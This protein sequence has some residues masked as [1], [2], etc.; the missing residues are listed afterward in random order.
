MATPQSRAHELVLQFTHLRNAWS[1][2]FPH[3]AEGAWKSLAQV[4]VTSSNSRQLDLWSQLQGLKKGNLSAHDY[5]SKMKNIVD[6]LVAIGQPVPKKQQILYLF[7]GLGPDYNPF[8]TSFNARVETP[9]IDEV[10]CLLLNYDFR[11]EKQN[12]VEQINFP[13]GN[14][15]SYPSNKRSQKQF[16]PQF[17]SQYNFPKSHPTQVQFYQPN[18]PP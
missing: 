3:T 2:F 14:L 9:T 17:P 4:H 5:V 16:S 15:S 11:L 8:V 13:Q 6:K 18:K 10:H 12:S 7:Q 1:D